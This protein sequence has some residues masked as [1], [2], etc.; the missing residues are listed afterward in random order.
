MKYQMI[1][2][3][4]LSE[5]HFYRCINVFQER[6]HFVCAFA[7]QQ[8]TCEVSW[9]YRDNVYVPL[10]HFVAQ[11][12]SQRFY[13]KLGDAVRGSIWWRKPPL[14]AAHVNNPSWKKGIEEIFKGTGSVKSSTI[15]LQNGSWKL[16][17]LDMIQIFLKSPWT[18]QLWQNGGLR[19][20]SHDLIRR[21]LAVT[22]DNFII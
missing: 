16:V 10:A 5:N 21:F 1:I 11:G 13:S 17:S 8:P 18:I 3:L 2:F 19:P 14:D 4:P 20:V 15:Q 7:H 22:S 12:I 9:F 6:R